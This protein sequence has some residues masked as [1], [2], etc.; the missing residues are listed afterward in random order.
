[1]LQQLLLSHLL[2]LFLWEI[3]VKVIIEVIEIIESK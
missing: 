3:R 2:E 1:M